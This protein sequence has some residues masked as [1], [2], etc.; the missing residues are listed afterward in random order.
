MTA[1][2]GGLAIDTQML[3]Q[4][5]PSTGGSGPLAGGWPRDLSPATTAT[6]DDASA[7]TRTVTGASY[8]SGSDDDDEDAKKKSAAAANAGR[9]KIDIEYIT[10]RPFLISEVL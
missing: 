3:L 4:P 10:V 1:A 5:G 6:S 2:H 8:D 7:R 9:R